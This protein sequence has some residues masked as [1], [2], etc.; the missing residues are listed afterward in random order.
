MYTEVIHEWQGG[1][2]AGEGRGLSMAYFTVIMIP[3]SP[4]TSPVVVFAFSFISFD[5]M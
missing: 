1:E 3:I 4:N 5:Q 2:C